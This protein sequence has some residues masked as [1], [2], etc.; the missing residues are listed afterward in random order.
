MYISYVLL[1]YIIT[2]ISNMTHKYTIIP[3]YNQKDSTFLD[4]FISTDTLHVSGGSSVHYEEHTT[5]HTA[6]GIVNDDSSQQHY[7][8]TIP[9]AVCTV[10][11]S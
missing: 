6:S 8:L 7:W 5:V 11:C 3:N 2:S 4:L 10:T 9:E 1:T